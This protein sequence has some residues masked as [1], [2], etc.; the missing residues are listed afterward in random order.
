M[1]LGTITSTLSSQLGL[2][3]GASSATATIC[4]KRSDHH[5]HQWTQRWTRGCDYFLHGVAV[6]VRC[7][8]HR[9]I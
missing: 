2:K 6:T 5:Q 1:T 3:S 4:R 8:T 9:R 7:Q